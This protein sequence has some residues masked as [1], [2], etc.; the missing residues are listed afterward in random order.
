MTGL[1]KG[2]TENC[3]VKALVRKT[4]KQIIWNNVHCPLIANGKYVNAN[5]EQ[6]NPSPWQKINWNGGYLNHY[7]T[8]STEEFAKRR[9]NKKDACGNVVASNDKL[10]E[11]YFNLNGRSKKAEDYFK[12]YLN[13]ITNS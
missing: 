10:I 2:V 1:P 13:E 9:F 6:V 8:K 3:H 11:R 7:I 4:N 12:E 5:L